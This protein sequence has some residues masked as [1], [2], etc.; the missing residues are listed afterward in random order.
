MRH[1]KGIKKAVSEI[2][3][4]AFNTRGI[5]YEV[6]YD[7]AK[8]EVFTNIQVS[9]GKNWWSTYDDENIVKVGNFDTDITMAGL[10]ERIQEAI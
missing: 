9:L 7:K 8:D 2:R 3:E 5:Y 4:I 6:F 10:K 1:F